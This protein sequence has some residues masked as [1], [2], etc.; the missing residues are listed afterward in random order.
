MNAAGITQKHVS[1]TSFHTH[2]EEGNVNAVSPSL[3]KAKPTNL[4]C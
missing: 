3:A 2:T 1:F 4:C